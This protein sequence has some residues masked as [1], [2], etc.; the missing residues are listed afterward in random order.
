MSEERGLYYTMHRGCLA[1][2]V[3]QYKGAS[4]S[5]FRLFVNCMKSVQIVIRT[6]FISNA[7]LCYASSI[8]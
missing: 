3:L 5:G 2:S 8:P 6:N 4:S 7:H 1:L